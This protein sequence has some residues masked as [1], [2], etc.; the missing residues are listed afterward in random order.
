[1]PAETG[2]PCPDST[3][4]TRR[5]TLLLTG[6]AGLALADILIHADLSLAKKKK[7]K[8]CKKRCKKAKK[9]CNRACKELDTDVELCKNEC[10]IAQKQCR[11]VC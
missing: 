3:T 9:Q 8:K 6:A 7:H 4:I 10:G 2:I 1:M 5:R 11:K